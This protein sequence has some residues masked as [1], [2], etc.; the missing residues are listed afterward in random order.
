MSR[1]S[2]F[3]Q[4]CLMSLDTFRLIA[5]HLPQTHYPDAFHLWTAEVHGLDYFLTVD[6]KF[7]NVMSRTLRSALHA[8]P[9]SPRDLLSELGIKEL[10]ELPIHDWE[11]H[12][13]A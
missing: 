5:C 2:E 12:D 6:K 11:I 7:I 9:I 1:F 8:R 3:E 4:R 13:L 10:D